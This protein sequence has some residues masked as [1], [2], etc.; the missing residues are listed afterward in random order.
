MAVAARVGRMTS[1]SAGVGFGFSS[2]EVGAR[3]G[4]QHAW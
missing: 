1:L 3:A 4:F 2:G